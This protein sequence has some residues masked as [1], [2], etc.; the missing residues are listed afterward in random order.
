MIKQSLF[1]DQEREVKLNELGDTLRIL[2][3]HV[4]ALAAAVDAAA[5]RP[6]RERGG[7]PPFPTELMVRVTA[8]QTLALIR[9]IHSEFN[10]AYP[11]AQIQT[12]IV[13]LIRNSTTLAA[14]KDR[15]ELAGALKPV[16]QAA[17]ADLAAGALDDFE[18]GPWGKKFPTVPA[19]RRLSPVNWACRLLW[20]AATRPT[21]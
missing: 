14:W 4:V 7:R 3:Q 19:T 8:H 5:P 2:E 10:G 13:H 18:T 9:A 6:S 12:C 15:K 20:A 16:Y 17:N 21:C 1:A 11:Q